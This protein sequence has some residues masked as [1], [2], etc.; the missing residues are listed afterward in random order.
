MPLFI[1]V[2]VAVIRM[3]FDSCCVVLTCALVVW[4]ACMTR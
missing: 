4:M 1:D 3:L 2:G